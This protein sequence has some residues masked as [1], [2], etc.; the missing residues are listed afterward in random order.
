MPKP[1]LDILVVDL[2]FPFVC[3]TYMAK[4]YTQESSVDGLVEF[5]KLLQHTRSEM[6]SINL[7][8]YSTVLVCVT[9]YSQH[10]TNIYSMSLLSSIGQWSFNL[11][12]TQWC[13]FSRVGKR[14]AK[15][16]WRCFSIGR[17]YEKYTHESLLDPLSKI[18]NLFRDVA[19][20][21]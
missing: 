21:Y 8:R 6:H 3:M 2:S 20:M 17:V 18:L 16:H 10:L 1:S 14:V 13:R 15:C 12:N 7:F 19:G 11:K 9:C 5:L 4:K